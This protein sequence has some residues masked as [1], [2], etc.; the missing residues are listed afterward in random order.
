M[1]GGQMHLENLIFSTS[2][3]SDIHS[4]EYLKWV[5][6]SG[7]APLTSM[8]HKFAEWLLL[9]DNAKMIRKVGDLEIVFKSIRKYL[10]SKGQ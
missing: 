8:Q 7:M 4:K 5:E 2:N 3:Q 9:E 1:N 6:Q 10:K